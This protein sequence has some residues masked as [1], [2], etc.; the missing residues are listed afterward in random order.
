MW[1]LAMGPVSSTSDCERDAWLWPLSPLV[2]YGSFPAL[3]AL[4]PLRQRKE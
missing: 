2:S 1:L 4:R 3:I